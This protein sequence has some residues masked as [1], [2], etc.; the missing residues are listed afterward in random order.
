MIEALSFPF[1]VRDDA[2]RR[3][4]PSS[5]R[6]AKSRAQQRGRRSG[7]TQ[8]QGLP[9]VTGSRGCWLSQHLLTDA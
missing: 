9:L 5:R 2:G 7:R 3:D 8:T 4:G 1:R 6:Q